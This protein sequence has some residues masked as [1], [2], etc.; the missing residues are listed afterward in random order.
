MDGVRQGFVQQDIIS[1]KSHEQYM[2]KNSEFFW[3]C[4]DKGHPIGYIGIIDLDIRIATHP[5]YQGKGIAS[6]MLKEVMKSNPDAI[7]KVKIDNRASLRLFE[8]CGFKKRYY[9]LEKD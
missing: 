5:N 9:L 7:A 4:I 3:I 8:K 1:K 6:F 2:K